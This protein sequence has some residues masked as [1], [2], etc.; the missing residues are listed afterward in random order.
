MNNT[1]KAK[2]EINKSVK[3]ESPVNR[4]HFKPSAEQKSDFMNIDDIPVGA[5]KKSAEGG[6]LSFGFKG[7]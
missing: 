5:N 2:I 7:I 3:R 4:N 6:K 1:P